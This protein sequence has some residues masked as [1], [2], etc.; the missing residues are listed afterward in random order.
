MNRTPRILLVED[1]PYDLEL[2]LI[3]LRRSNLANEIDIARDGEEALNYLLGKEKFEDRRPAD[4]CLI[5]LDVR[6]PKVDGLEVLRQIN[7]DEALSR[8]P[9]VIMT[10]S[11]HERDAVESHRLGVKAYLEKPIDLSQ[12]HLAL[13]N[14][15]MYWFMS[16]SQSGTSGWQGAFA[17]S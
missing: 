5:L 6:L 10:G 9:V 2:S 15:G 16:S 13:R 8:I 3:A 1:N 17:A 14:L 11:P 12:F 4:L 7:A